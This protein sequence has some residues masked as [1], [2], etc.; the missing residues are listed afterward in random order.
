[1]TKS[2]T[3]ATAGAVQDR[4]GSDSRST[5]V[6]QL[7]TYRP[8][9]AWW[10]DLF[11]IGLAVVFFALNLYVVVQHAMHRDEWN[12]WQVARHTPSLTDLYNTI[13]HQGHA[14]GFYTIAWFLCRPALYPF[15]LKFFHVLLSTGCVYLFARYAPFTR[16]QKLLFA[17]GYFPFYQ[18]GAILRN[19]AAEEFFL[20]IL[21]AL[22]VMPHRRPIALGIVLAPM[23]QIANAF[24]L[25]VGIALV[26]PTSSILAVADRKRGQS[27]F[28]RST[29]RAVPTNGDFP[30]FRIRRC[31]ATRLAAELRLP[32]FSWRIRS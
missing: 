4:A 32:A 28:V 11:A 31:V 5:D 1:M 9:L 15:A 26:R 22:F 10:A 8:H 27:P 14:A 17:F 24:G 25:V 13:G 18:Y 21:C 2:A 23:F 30:L 12:T 19:Y 20:V 6:A 29:R 7:P 16:P 3:V